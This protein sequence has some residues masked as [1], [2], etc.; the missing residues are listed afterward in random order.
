MS[1]CG[2][3][4]TN[5]GNTTNITLGNTTEFLPKS[6]GANNY[7]DYFWSTNAKGLRL[8]SPGG[9][10]SY[11]SL[12]GLAALISGIGVG[13]TISTLSFRCLRILN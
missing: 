4:S 7:Y 2:Y 12:A 10:A 8:G 6:L 11:G 9:L 3:L 5:S 1:I 13:L